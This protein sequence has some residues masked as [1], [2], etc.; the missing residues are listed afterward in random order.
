M[1]IPVNYAGQ[2]IMYIDVFTA[3]ICQ[4]NSG[5]MRSMHVR[6]ISIAIFFSTYFSFR[7]TCM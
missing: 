2:A 3:V 4:V 5:S 7:L 6:F 1:T